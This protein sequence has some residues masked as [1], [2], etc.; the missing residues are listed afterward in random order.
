VHSI[1]FIRIFGSDQSICLDHN[2]F[3]ISSILED[4][5]RALNHAQT[6]IPSAVKRDPSA[7]APPSSD[8]K[9]TSKY[10]LD[11]IQVLQAL[12]NSIVLTPDGSL[13]SYCFRMGR[14]VVIPPLASTLPQQLIQEQ[15]ETRKSNQVRLRMFFSGSISLEK[16]ND[17][18][19]AVVMLYGTTDDALGKPAQPKGWNGVTGPLE[20]E[21]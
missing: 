3:R 20:F 1:P 17:P 15:H 6:A 10:E 14:D 19:Y 5:I 16:H 12:Q 7:I 4:S 21:F 13:N 11:S 8:N 2:E 9:F 18:W